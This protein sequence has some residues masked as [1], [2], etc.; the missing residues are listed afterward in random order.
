MRRLIGILVGL[1]ALSMQATA[2][3]DPL[4]LNEETGFCEL[5]ETLNGPDDLP[6]T[7]RRPAGDAPCADGGCKSVV[8]TGTSAPK[9]RVI[10]GDIAFG[11]GTY[12][13][14]GAAQ[15][16]LNKVAAVMNDPRS[17][18]QRYRI[19][20][21]TDRKGSDAYNRRLSL[22][23]AEV[24]KQYLVQAGVEPDRLQAIG[25]SYHNLLDSNRPYDGVNRRVEFVKQS[26]NR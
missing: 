13:L 24:V 9:T 7:C 26:G 18:G 8:I 25:N 12:A 6:A 19:E 1:S 23:R 22:W 4:I 15:R 16:Q 5:F 10:L 17:I 11:H 14:S 21:N 2:S 20:G 3:A